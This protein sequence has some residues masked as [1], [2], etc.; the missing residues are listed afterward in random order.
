MNDFQSSGLFLLFTTVLSIFVTLRYK[1]Q[2]HRL[3]PSSP[4][5]VGQAIYVGFLVLVFVVAVLVFVEFGLSN[6]LGRG[7]LQQKLSKLTMMTRVEGMV[8]VVV[9]V[10]AR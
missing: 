6:V 4:L 8:L 1:M 7:R 9:E 3:H 5:H 10:E 2:C